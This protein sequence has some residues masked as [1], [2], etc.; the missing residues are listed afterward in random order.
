MGCKSTSKIL[1][2]L[3]RAYILDQRDLKAP[4][5]KQTKS[6]LALHNSIFQ[7]KQKQKTRL[8][9]EN[10]IKKKKNSPFLA[11]FGLVSGLEQ[12]EVRGKRA[13]GDHT[14]VALGV[15]GSAEEHVVT[16]SRVLN[17]GAL[18]GVGNGAVDLVVP[19]P[20]SPVHETKTEGRVLRHVDQSAS[21][22]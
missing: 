20:A 8:V 17:P 18:C 22:V 7:T 5:N 12:V 4:R 19:Q 15:I 13:G 16:E 10:A 3:I 14:G 2:N 11:D 6:T 21:E 1:Q 9:Y